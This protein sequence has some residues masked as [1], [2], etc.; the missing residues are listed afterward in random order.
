MLP[1]LSCISVCPSSCRCDSTGAVMCVGHSITDIPKQLPLYM[2]TLRLNDTNMNVINENSLAN[3]H[4]LLRFS[5]S[6]SHLHTIHPRA[7]QVVPQLKSVKLSSNDLS[8]IPA[9]VFSPLT[10]LEQLH[11][12]GNQLET[13]APDMLEGLIVLLDLNLSHNKLTSL[14]SDVFRR[15]TKLTNLNLSRNSIKKLSPTIFRLLTSLRLLSI[16]YNEIEVLEAG[17]FD[18]LVNLEELKIHYNQISSLAPRV[19][20]SLRNLKT[21]TMSSNRLQAI[22]EKTFYNMPKLS[23][24]T[25]FKNPLLSLPDQLMG[26]MPE[27][28]EFYLFAT[29]LTTVPGNL[30]ANMSGLLSLNFHLNDKL[31]EL[32]SDLFCC[33]PNLQK[34]SLR[35]N[36]LHYLHPQLFARLTTLA[37]LLLNDNKLQSLPE[38]IFQ[39]HGGLL[40]IELKNN[41]L[42]TLPG[43]IFWSTTALKTL[44]LSGNPWDCTC[45]IR[46]IWRWISLNEHVV[47]DNEDVMCHSPT[48]QIHRTIR[49]LCDEDFNF[50]NATTPQSN[51]P[52]EDSFEP[53]QP[54][55]AITTDRQPS[56]AAPVTTPLRTISATTQE[57][58]QRAI[59]STTTQPAKPTT[60][61]VANSLPTIST[62][63]PDDELLLITETLSYDALPFYG[64]LVV[65]QGPEFIHHNFHKGWVYVWFLPSDTALAGFLMFSHMLLVVTGLFMIFCAMYTMYRLN[66]PVDQL[67]ADCA[68]TSA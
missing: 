11:L 17:I 28:R 59:S 40:I 21:L 57:P 38:N 64:Q 37:T 10:D 20:W 14:E 19:F 3:Q 29:N 31:R 46:G 68:N 41:H 53:T 30:F 13:I 55:H 7:F 67:K 63:L 1:Q 2:Y 44:T 8:T 36:D 60:S 42:K 66:R 45:S 9:Q 26:H 52:T 6:Y 50:C 33:L 47:T 12:D 61:D 27:M 24:L 18:D 65:E 34:L 15:L 62:A 54:P 5:L 56:V 43:N 51:F 16:Q 39:G 58:T 48:Y 4:L 49:S 25:I 22:P 35:S 23:K 32:P